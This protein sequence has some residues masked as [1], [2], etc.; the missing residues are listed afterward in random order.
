[1][2]QFADL[3]HKL[4][5]PLIVIFRS[6]LIALLL[7]L[8]FVIFLLYWFVILVTQYPIILTLPPVAA[9]SVWLLRQYVFDREITVE[10][11]TAVIV[12]KAHGRLKP[13][14]R[15]WHRLRIGDRVCERFSLRSKSDETNQEE[16]LTR[17]GEPVRLSSVYEYHISDPIRFYR[18]GRKKTLDFV[19][20]NQ[21]VLTGVIREFSFDD[22]YNEPFEIN[23]LIE[24]ITNDQL[25]DCGLQVNNYYLDEAIWPETNERWRRIRSNLP[26]Q[27]NRYWS[28]DRSL[29]RQIR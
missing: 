25:W 6:L 27:G 23:E 15:G 19:E 18:W 20:L 24:Q 10:K 1:M 13:L 12:R 29:R 17:E 4:L 26:L 7:V 28:E 5:S 16:V 21:W 3:L 22:L 9:L 14:Y 8:G 2:E 11:D